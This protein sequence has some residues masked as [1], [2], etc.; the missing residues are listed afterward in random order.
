MQAL[1]GFTAEFSL[2]KSRRVYQGSERSIIG[3][4]GIVMPSDVYP[5]PVDT[6][7]DLS[8][9]GP[10]TGAAYCRNH[11]RRCCERDSRGKCTI[12]V[13]GCQMCP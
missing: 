12:W 3:A 10:G 4:P 5:W 7:G 11:P 6:D 2:Y 9:A 13:A 1:P 8:D